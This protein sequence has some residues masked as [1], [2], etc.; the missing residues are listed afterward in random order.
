MRKLLVLLPVLLLT[1]CGGCLES[2]HGK[3]VRESMTPIRPGVPGK[4]PFWN[5]QAKQFIYAPAFD[6]PERSDCGCTYRFT[7]T[8]VT[9]ARHVF[10]A[11]HPWAPLSPIWGELPVGRTTLKVEPMPPSGSLCI[12]ELTGTRTFHRGAVFNGPYGKAVLPYGQSAAVALRSVLDEPFVQAWR[13][14]GK[15]DPNYPLYRYAAKIIPAV[16]SAAAFSGETKDLEIGKKA[17]D[18]LISISMPAGGPLECM[19][20]TY[21]TTRPTDRENDNFEMMMTP[22]ESG[23]GY[24][25]LYDATKETKYLEGAQRIAGTYVKLQMASGTW[26]LKVDNRTNEPIVPYDL[27]PTAVINFLDRM[28]RVLQG[29]TYGAARQRAVKWVMENPVRTFNW[30]AQFDD[31]KQRGAYENLSKHEACEFAWYLFEHGDV[32]TAEEL[33][34]FSE[35]QFVVWERPPD[36]T[37]RSMNL[38]P[39]LWFTPCSTE[40]YAM[41][42]PISGSSAFMI[43]TYIRAYQATG[44][45]LH[46]A[47]AQSLANALTV[48]QQ[49]H[50]GRYPTRMVREDLAYW[51]NS[52][53]NTIRAMRALAAVQ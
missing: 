38:G 31:A 22:A 18:Y 42:E 9:G 27:V 32:K 41:F 53:M 40:Q 26:R 23:E 43:M 20:P 50:H 11:E 48:A 37:P 25:D 28:D 14:T 19:P 5:G 3:S 15:P 52:T 6:F 24:L 29:S 46:L 34:R 21:H 51:I 30:Q 7:A 4:S 44:D 33:L 8:D 13:I 16:M 39:Q 1:F 12:I 36:L 49:Y 2:L 35:D 10:T 17:A 45:K 47:R